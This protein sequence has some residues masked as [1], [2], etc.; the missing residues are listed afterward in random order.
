M[1]RLFPVW[2]EFWEGVTVGTRLFAF[3]GAHWAHCHA[4]R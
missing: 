3:E 4:P 1:F 2:A